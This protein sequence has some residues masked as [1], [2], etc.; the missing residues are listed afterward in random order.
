MI[1]NVSASV[2]MVE[3]NPLCMQSLFGKEEV[4]FFAVLPERKNRFMLTKKKRVFGR[5]SPLLLLYGC[6]E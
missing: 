6:L 5:F 4:A 3:G 2:N 1:G